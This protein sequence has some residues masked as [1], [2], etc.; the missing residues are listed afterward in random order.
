MTRYFLGIDIGGS[1]SHALI[2]DDSG[3]AVGFGKGGAGNYKVVG[4]DGLRQTLHTITEQAL[5]SASIGR[6][7]VSGAGLGVAGYDW[8][9]EAEPT[10]HAI[11]ASVGRSD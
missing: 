1:K 7:Q 6:D 5:A 4:W 9:A 11:S 8:P 2:A 10:R 3:R